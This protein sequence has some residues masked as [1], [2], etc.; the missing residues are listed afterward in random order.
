MAKYIVHFIFICFYLCPKAQNADPL[1]KAEKD[2]EKS[3]LQNGIRDG[4]LA[5]VDSNGIEFNDKGPR[6]AKKFWSSL[7]AFDG[8]FS[9]SP[10]FA[11][12]SISGSWGYTTG[13][14]EHRLKT[15]S[16]SVEASGQYTTVWHKIEN[17]EWKYLIDI[18]NGHAHI[19]P[20]QYAKTIATEKRKA[21]LNGDEP[22]LADQENLFIM[23]FEKSTRDAYQKFGSS[24]YILN[25]TGQLP[26][27]S[28]DTAVALIGKYQPAWKYHPAGLMISNG[29]DMGAV[30]GTFSR[31]EKTGNYIRIWRHEQTGW[32]IALEV[33]KF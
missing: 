29:D 4:F 18:G 15:L 17:G 12:M 5:F 33:I 7:P 6:N 25:L 27:I 8:V 23:S 3:C 28:T 32:K 26:V 22:G 2:F 13:N 9:W 1:I 16:D 11:E 10:S 20:E 14:F 21:I 30:Y 31:G 19:P 24:S